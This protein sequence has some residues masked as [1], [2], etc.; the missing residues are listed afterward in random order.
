V[1]ISI[2]QIHDKPITLQCEESALSFPLLA[3]MQSDGACSFAGPVRCDATVVRE[4]DHL[5]V[6][7]RVVVP[8]SLVCS[9][10]LVVYEAT[11]DSSF[12][13][14]FRKGTSEEA[15]LEDET[16]L[17]EQDLVSAVYHGDEI[18]MTHEIEEQIAMEV[19][20]QPLC[21][22]GCKGLCPECGTDLNHGTCSC[23]ARQFNFK[24]SALK[25][26]KA[27]R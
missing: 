5:R 10:C 20:F 14:I 6:A 1:K 16:E 23:S 22:D 17:S 9:R 3:E 24:F 12:T 7:G 19:P 15:S 2:D 8:V 13:I 18:D 25:D 21:S 11:L 4:Y 26:F 27:S